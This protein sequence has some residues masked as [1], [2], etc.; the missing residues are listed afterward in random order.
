MDEKFSKAAKSS[1]FAFGQFGGIPASVPIRRDMVIQ[2][3]EDITSQA[4][5]KAALAQASRIAAEA[6][7][8]LEWRLE[9]LSNARR[10]ESDARWCMEQAQMLE[11]WIG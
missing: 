11:S 9:H 7:S 8:D 3:R 5:Q 2:M 6:T 10:F 4:T 1:F